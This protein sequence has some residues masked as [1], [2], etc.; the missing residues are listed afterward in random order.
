MSTWS[1]SQLDSVF[2]NKRGIQST[3]SVSFSDFYRGGTNVTQHS[4]LFD[5][6]TGGPIALSNFTSGVFTRGESYFTTGNLFTTTGNSQYTFTVPNGVSSLSIVCVGGGG[7]GG[8]GI[9]T[10][11]TARGSGGGGALYYTNNVSVSAG[12]T[13]LVNVGAGGIGFG[14]WGGSSWVSLANTVY[15]PLGLTSNTASNITGANYG[16]GTYLASSSSQH[17]AGIYQAYRAFDK[18]T[19]NYLTNTSGNSNFW[20]CVS[21][22]YFGSS[23][24][25]AGSVFTTTPFRSYPPTEGT[26]TTI[27]N[28][29]G[30]TVGSASYGNG[31]YSISSNTADSDRWKLVDNNTSTTFLGSGGRYDTAGI[32]LGGCRLPSGA[33]TANDGA[34][35]GVTVG[36]GNF[37]ITGGSVFAGSEFFHAFDRNPATFWKSNGI[38]NTA[39]GAYSGSNTLLSVPGEDIWFQ[40]DATVFNITPQTFTIT[41]NNPNTAPRTFELYNSGSNNTSLTITELQA[42]YTAGNWVTNP[43][44]TFTTG[45]TNSTNWS[46][47]RTWAL[48]VTRIGN[49]GTS[50]S[51]AEIQDMFFTNCD[52]ITLTDI[53]SQVYEGDTITVTLPS[54]IKLNSLLVTGREFAGPNNFTLFGITSGNFFPLLSTG[55]LTFNAKTQASFTVNSNTAS[56]V[57]YNQFALSVKSTLGGGTGAIQ[58]RNLNFIEGTNYSGEWLQIQLPNNI[59][60]QNYSITPRTDITAPYSNTRSPRDFVVLGSTDGSIWTLLDQ[61]TD[62]TS[63]DYGSIKQ[64]NVATQGSYNYYRLVTSRV[65]T[66]TST[67]DNLSVQIAEWELNPNYLCLAQGGFGGA[68]IAFLTASGGNYGGSWGG[69]T[70]GCIGT[71]GGA[72]GRGAYSNIIGRGGGGAGG[73]IGSGGFGG[74]GGVDLDNLQAFGGG[75]AG[76]GRID[77]GNTTQRNQNGHGGGGVGLFGIGVSGSVGS[78]VVGVGSFGGV[79]GS[80]GTSGSLGTIAGQV[81]VGGSFGGGGGSTDDITTATQSGSGGAGGVRIVWGTQRQFPNEHVGRLVDYPPIGLTGTSTSLIV[82]SSSVVSQPYGNGTYI[83]S[84][85][86]RSRESIF[87][88]FDRTDGNTLRTRTGFGTDEW[89]APSSGNYIGSATNGTLAGD[90][91]Y[92]GEYLQIQLPAPIQLNSYSIIPAHHTTHAS[93]TLTPSD[94][95][96]LGSNNGSTWALLDQR[97][98]YTNWPTIGSLQTFTTSS[99]TRTSSAGTF[100]VPYSYY[101]L[102]ASRVGTLDNDTQNKQNRMFINQLYLNGFETTSLVYPPVGLTTSQGSITAAY[103]SGTYTA[104]ASTTFS[105]NFAWNAFDNNLM[106]YWNSNAQYNGTTGAYTGTASTTV[107]STAYPGEWLQLQLPISIYLHSHTLLGRESFL[108]RVAGDY[109]LAGSTGGTVW[110]LIET[111]GNLTLSDYNSGGTLHGSFTTAVPA[112]SPFSY[113]RLITSKLGPIGTGTQR[114]SVNMNWI[115]RGSTTR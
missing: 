83:I 39:N 13:L 50:G 15:P 8:L 110:S 41:C 74:I 92:N 40:Y 51:Y 82:T 75:G 105:P 44:Q 70:A 104:S 49:G 43:T 71:F 52:S 100:I 37:T 18:I 115:L 11:S 111:R 38:Y 1:F 47:R 24:N 61:E 33:C 12:Q 42:R 6:P 53:D 85:S 27:A 9:N 76:G 16:N 28:A 19:P 97:V 29:V 55:S 3:G 59:T 31:V 106:T 60:L 20:H 101:R 66:S 93:I 35:S 56:N 30:V 32:Y 91:T 69:F 46:G 36:N 22:V 108:S 78:L 89:Y 10:S 21:N 94:F 45:N 90:T 72:G 34:I 67:T 79:G 64:F 54:S 87:N 80:G 113:Y 96:M 26:L 68:T 107:G 102:Q 114:T 81:G 112:S 86:S 14:G 98:R 65:G 73:Y 63:W 62:V 109:I 88:P 7:G 84:A 4:Y 57:A 95:V 58:I 17:V 2:G 77:V 5:I 99:F 103:G 48:L 23:G 25:Y